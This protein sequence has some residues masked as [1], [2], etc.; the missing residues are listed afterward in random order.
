MIWVCLYAAGCLIIAAWGA[1]L[2][3]R[4]LRELKNGGSGGA[5]R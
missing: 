3:C 4:D 1:I 2:F 5:D